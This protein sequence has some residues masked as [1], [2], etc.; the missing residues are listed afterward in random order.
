MYKLICF[1]VLIICVGKQAGA[2][3]P[4]G[5]FRNPLDIPIELAGN[6]GECRPNHFHS[7]IDIKTQSKENFK[8]YAAADGYIS[9]IKMER[10]G[11]GHALYVTHPNGYTTLYAHLNDFI[12]AVQKHMKTKQYEKESWELDIQLDPSQFPVKKGQQIAWSGNTG[13]STAPH[14]HFEIRDTK[15]EHPLNAQLFGFNV[16]DNIS[17]KPTQIAIY[18]LTRSIYEQKPQ[19]LSLVNKGIYTTAN[20]IIKIHAP[21]A[22][23]GINVFDYMNGSSNTLAFY[24]AEV[25]MDDMPAGK[26]TLDDIGYDVTRYLHAYTDIKTKKNIGSWI[27]LM[28][29]LPG[30]ELDHIYE[31][32]EQYGLDISDGQTHDVRIVLK[33]VYGNSTDI[34]TALQYEPPATEFTCERMWMKANQQNSFEHPNV[35]F[36]LDEAALYDDVC[37]QFSADTDIKNYSDRYQL[38]ESSIPVHTY[39]TLYLKPNKPV[40][41][42]LRDKIVIMQSDG[43]DES[44]R[45]AKFGDEG[46]YSAKVRSFGKYWLVSDNTA[47]VIRS[48][49]K[50]NNLSTAKSI[51]FTAKD[52]ITSVKEFRA[53]LDGKW[54][55]FEKR[56][57]TYFYIFDEHCSKGKHT[58]VVTAR[59]ENDNVQT[60]KYSFTR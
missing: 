40:P 23:L 36:T 3:Y 43:K 58:L 1:A 52:D 22:G 48:L 19:I 7:G 26:I 25:Y 50:S 11:F 37:F 29:K 12:P 21:K 34:K 33:D 38:H 14:L 32:F 20:S 13:G 49:Q 9:R 24:T 30:N 31:G 59:D 60:L 53:E 16:T 57:S 51:S 47:P 42:E 17:P 28:F 45:A 56:G 41:F 46:W 2:Q 8:V 27:Q 18:D 6:F 39:F 44:G 10:G 54:L 55:C 35:K 5:Y 15:T 4:Q